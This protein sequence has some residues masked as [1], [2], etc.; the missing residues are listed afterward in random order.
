MSIPSLQLKK[1]GVQIIIWEEYL[2]SRWSRSSRPF[3]VP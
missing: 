3:K 1:V 2:S